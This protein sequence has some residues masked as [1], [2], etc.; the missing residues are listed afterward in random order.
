MCLRGRWRVSIYVSTCVCAT[1][2]VGLSLNRPYKTN[3]FSWLNLMD[4]TAPFD[5]VWFSS[6]PSNYRNRPIKYY[7]RF[8][9]A[10]QT[11]LHVSTSES[12]P[13]ATH[14]HA[15]V[16]L[17]RAHMLISRLPER[18]H[19][20]TRQ[21]RARVLQGAQGTQHN[22]K[23]NAENGSSYGFTCAKEIVQL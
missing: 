13:I 7:P 19:T 11:L 14:T 18:T 9:V 17:A 2:T 6:F 20:F 16:T 12:R 5:T 21:Q 3:P 15:T 22:G 10:S 1:V 8:A 23:S 4:K